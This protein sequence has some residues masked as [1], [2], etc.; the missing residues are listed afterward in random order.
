MENLILNVAGMHT[1]TCAD[2]IEK[3]L[4]STK[5]ISSV[6][7]NFSSQNAN[8]S[9]NEYEID[10]K[11]IIKIIEKLGYR[12]AKI[13]EE[14]EE[15]KRKKSLIKKLL[16]K[17]VI[18]GLI[19]LFILFVPAF[20]I[21][22]KDVPVLFQNLL[23]L[24]LIVAEIYFGYFEV[25]KNSVLNIINFKY[26]HD[27]LHVVGL[28]LLFIYTLILTV[29]E[30]LSPYVNRL[31]LLQI[32]A[33]ITFILVFNKWLREKFE[34]DSR[35]YYESLINLKTKTARVIRHNTEME[36]EIAG[37]KVGDLIKVKPGEAF[38]VDGI[39][40]EG[41][42]KVNET[43][44]AGVDEISIKK[45]G[46]EVIGATIN[47]DDTVIL[48]ATQVGKETT[49]EQV[50]SLVD[51]SKKHK[52]SLEKLSPKFEIVYSVISVI[53]ALGAYILWYFIGGSGWFFGGFMSCI[54][55]LFMAFPDGFVFGTKMP[56][57]LGIEKSSLKGIIYK[58]SGAIEQLSK[59]NRLVIDKTGILTLGVP[60][61]T[62]II[63]KEGFNEKRFLIMI[64]SLENSST[65]PFADAITEYCKN[66]NVTL[67]RPY[68]FKNIEGMGIMGIVDGQE[69]IAGNM[70]LME[71]SNVQM[72]KDLLHKAEILSKNVRTP[73]YIARNRELVGVIGI[74]DTIRPEAK[75]AVAE[76]NKAGL[77]L[78]IVT[79]DN[80][81][82]TQNI[83][84]DLR[85][86]D[87][88]AN[89]QQKEK[90][91]AIQDYQTDN[92]SVAF[93]G[94][95]I[96]DGPVLA[97]ADLGIALGTGTDTTLSVSDVSCISKDLNKINQAYTYAK[98]IKKAV[99]RNFLIT[100]FYNLLI[101]PVA[102]GAL[103]PILHLIM[104]PA[105]APAA[106][107]GLMALLMYNSKKSVL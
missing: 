14:N 96:D 84:D 101:L 99:I 103:Y 43:V 71:K 40:V 35:K 52:G 66:N 33:L 10:E 58:G 46:D 34:T 38:P 2:K 98:Q 107:T 25:I 75:N 41:E 50:I 13:I 69:V 83:A 90:I 89:A 44:L 31:F 20:L 24:L 28:I 82:I 105:L 37:I 81:K 15:Q 67:K 56:F 6:S 102:I 55:I 49:L 91:E 68:D 22:L 87:V 39:I 8:V 79:G 94:K 78:T 27:H 97:Q 18:T 86:N 45:A 3:T 88:V 36:I 76:L 30:N 92:E 61:I 7:V 21:Y 57:S 104:Y 62:N 5:G 77:K 63:T 70:K 54:V 11:K 53:C 65:H 93:V 17:Q 74:A 29:F 47:I 73:I 106:S 32:I 1:A 51:E 12:S 72:N 80:E 64:G 19:A 16:I 85:I 100:A 26:S 59:I 60:E 4:S 23:I 9:Y 95:G 42:T 48:K